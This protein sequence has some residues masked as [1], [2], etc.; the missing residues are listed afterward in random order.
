MIK[1]I[2]SVL[3]QLAM[4]AMAVMLPVPGVSADLRAQQPPVLPPV[5]IEG[6]APPPAGPRTIVGIVVD[7][8]DVPVDGIEILIPS[9]QRQTVSDSNGVFRFTDVRPGAYELRARH[10]GFAPQ[11]RRVT[12]EKQQGA[13]TKFM[14][15]RISHALPAVVSST[16]RGGL[17]GVVGDTAFTAIPGAAVSVLASDRRTETDSSGEFFL[18]VKPGRYMVQITRPGYGRK[19]L[20]VT[21]PNDSGR[22]I[23]VWMA[24]GRASNRDVAVTR[25]LAERLISRRATSAFFTNEDINRYNYQWLRELVVTGSGMPVSDDCDATVDG[26]W[27]TPVYALATDAIESVEVYPP[28][29]LPSAN[30]GRLSRTRPPTSINPAGSR[31]SVSTQRFTRARPGVVCPAV[32]VWTKR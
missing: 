6:R 12:V 29:T 17:S 28:G 1:P 5:R 4:L 9:L 30:D 11:I 32:F 14:L 8:A 31:G 7:T 22:R 25:D 26:I 10:L 27:R 2:P 16:T 18:D 15:L 24:P 13:I 23:I 20:S 3:H 21:V 19:L